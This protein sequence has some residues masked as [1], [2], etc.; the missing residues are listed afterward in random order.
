VLDFAKTLK[1]SA[2]DSMLKVEEL[3]EKTKDIDAE[4]KKGMDTLDAE[5]DASTAR[6][7][8]EMKNLDDL[9]SAKEQQLQYEKDM[10]AQK[11][12][13]AEQAYNSQK[14]GTPSNP[15]GTDP[16]GG[17]SGAAAKA[18]SEAQQ[19]LD[20]LVKSLQNETEV[21]NAHYAESLAILDQAEAN[22]IASIMPYH[23]LRERLEADHMKKL[24]EIVRDGEE[25]MS[26]IRGLNAFLGVKIQETAG[27][28]EIEA[29]AKTFKGLIDDAA[30]HS[31]AF[32]EMKKALALATALI[33][34][35]KAV[36]ASFAFG[37]EIGG[38]VVGAIFGG[39]A[40]AAVGVQVASIASAQYTAAKA[41]GG[42]VFAGG[43]YKVN[44][45]GPELLSTGGEDFLMMGSKGGK[46]TPNHMLGGGSGGE[47]APVN[48]IIN[49]FTD[50]KA[51]VREKDGVDGKTIEIILKHVDSALA[52]NII[53]GK[54]KIPRAIQQ[55]YRL[56]RGNRAKAS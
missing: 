40:A 9:R 4:W 7:E 38:P 2:D 35:P 1:K 29:Q 16:L 36:L 3:V 17:G 37:S 31:K 22:K 11:K 50:A 41:M 45:Q 54:G 42:N 20:A 49:N 5:G 27:S 8:A 53:E 44:E 13:L 24:N 21:E 55:T 28:M 6:Y 12:Y 47:A 23:E 43:A 56:G 48:V 32:F 15:K 10:A 39:I 14:P 19:R 30:E 52:G 51:T 34:A 33:D 18:A 26:A 46:I 25:E